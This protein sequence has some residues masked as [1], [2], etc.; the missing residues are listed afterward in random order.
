MVDEL[1][2]DSVR[3]ANL[4]GWARHTGFWVVATHRFGG[5]A[6]SLRNPLLRFP[7]LALH[8]VASLPWR[9]LLNVTIH[10]DLVGPGLCLIHPRNILIGPGVEIGEDCL[11]FHEVTIATGPTPGRPKIGRGVDVYVGARVLGGVTV[12]DGSMIGANCVVTRSVPPN[13]V[14]VAAPSR[15]L[16][17]TLVERGGDVPGTEPPR[18]KADR[19]AREP[20]VGSGR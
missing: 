12:G 3:Y 20:E 9:L 11:I 10:T 6:R 1:R 19:Q 4:G 13:S 14:V 15:I 5:W 18:P 2:R 16:S 7:L 8:R 17:R